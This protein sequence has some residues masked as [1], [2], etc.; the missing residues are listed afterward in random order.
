MK[1]IYGPV[2]SRRLGRSLGVSLVE[3]KTCSLDCLY[4]EA[5]ATTNLT[6]QRR[7]YVDPELVIAELTAALADAP[8]LDFITFSGYGE[9]TLNSAIGRIIDFIKSQY[10][11]YRLCLLTNAVAFADRSLWPELDKVDLIVPSLDASNEVEFATLNRP[12]P[13]IKFAK[14]LTDLRAFCEYNKSYKMLE[15]FIAPGINDSDDSIRRFAS[16]VKALKV[17]KVQLNTLDRPGC[18]DDLQPCDEAT[19][20]RFVDALEKIVPVETVGANAYHTP[21]AIT[22][23]EFFRKLRETPDGNAEQK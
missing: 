13:E 15:I 3:R 16:I 12:A 23:A 19:M 11:Q 9:P 8:E 17:D 20:Q 10:P 22:P 5:G 4:C 6:C 7:E 21:G 14:F 1:Y 18:L 2:A